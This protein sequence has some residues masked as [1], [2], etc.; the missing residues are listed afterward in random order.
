[1]RENSR[2]NSFIRAMLTLRCTFS[3]ILAASATRMPDAR[4]RSADTTSA[5]TRATSSSACPSFAD[6]IL[7][8]FEKVCSES[9]GLMRSGE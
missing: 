5:Y 4:Q 9:L 7:A 2:C 6:T 8:V 1:M 3:A